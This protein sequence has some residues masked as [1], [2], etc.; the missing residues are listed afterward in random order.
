MNALQQA[1]TF[2]ITI[3]FDLYIL[4]LLLRLL[5]QMAGANFYHPICQFIAKVTSPVLTPLHKCIPRFRNIDTAI[6]LLVLLLEMHKL[7]LVVFIEAQI[8]PHVG[9]L[10]L[11]ALGDLLNRVIHIYFFAILIYVLLSWVPVPQLFSIVEL[12]SSLVNP[13]L[14]PARRYIP[15]IAGIDLSP[16][17]VMIA[18]QLLGI[19]I[20]YP[21]INAGAALSIAP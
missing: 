10:L 17:A 5:L 7:L 3:A 6:V 12:L 21:L 8:F 20:S 11:W 19:L 2:I 18:L 1:I 15:L 13:L 16:L 9:G 14:R 4:A